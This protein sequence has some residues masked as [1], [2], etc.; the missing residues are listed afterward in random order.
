MT[1]KLQ[2][3]VRQAPAILKSRLSRFRF[4]LYFE[5]SRYPQN[6]SQMKM[7]PW[8]PLLLIRMIFKLCTF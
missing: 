3:V 6:V 4:Q 5:R 2:V 8:I 1:A 7:A